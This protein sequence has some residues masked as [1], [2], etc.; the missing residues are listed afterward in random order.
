MISKPL[1]HNLMHFF[2]EHKKALSK[3]LESCQNVILKGDFNIDTNLP[4]LERDRS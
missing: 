1:E 4:S 3:A 2:K